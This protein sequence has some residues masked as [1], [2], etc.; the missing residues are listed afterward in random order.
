[1]PTALRF[2]PV[3]VQPKGMAQSHSQDV[4][5]PT[6]HHATAAV[7]GPRGTRILSTWHGR[8]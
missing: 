2:I 8:S 3:A 4:I 1:M 6:R 5:S 7:P